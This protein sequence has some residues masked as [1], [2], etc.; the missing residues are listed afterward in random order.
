[1]SLS[2]MNQSQPRLED[3]IFNFIIAFDQ[4]WRYM[5]VKSF[6]HPSPWRTPKS[7]QHKIDRLLMTH[8]RWIRGIRGIQK[9]SLEQLPV[10]QKGNKNGIRCNDSDPHCKIWWW[11]IDTLRLF[12]PGELSTM[13]KGS[14]TS[15]ILL[16]CIQVDC[17][18][19]AGTES[20][21]CNSHLN[22]A[23]N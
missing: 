18:M 3:D 17:K 2:S 11:L 13:S 1:M 10:C 20:L 15:W 8:V 6:C 22:L 9:K 19:F 7:M 21:F 14:W 12:F 5:H 4:I 16:R 23:W